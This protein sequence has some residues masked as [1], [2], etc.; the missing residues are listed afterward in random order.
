MAGRTLA[1]AGPR[2]RTV[3]GRRWSRRRR[4]RGRGRA[5]RR[6]SRARGRRPRRWL[7]PT[8]RRVRGTRR[9]GPRWGR[10]WVREC[11]ADVVDAEA[12]LV[13]V[14]L[15]GGRERGGNARR[16]D[17]ASGGAT[18]CGEG[19]GGGRRGLAGCRLS[20]G[21]R[22]RVRVPLMVTTGAS[23][24]GAED[25]SAPPRWTRS[26][27]DTSVRRRPRGRCRIFMMSRAAADPRRARK[28][29]PPAA[30]AAGP[31]KGPAHNPRPEKKATLRGP[32]VG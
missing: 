6:G 28:G 17:V 16:R 22:A 9:E 26:A 15:G 23:E 21:S 10:G 18:A 31:R 19:R 30:T 2:K 1:S 27:F 12:V 13:A 8:G 4:A 5:R 32:R 20:T 25:A 3:A 24:R 7:W 11:A 29:C 14:G